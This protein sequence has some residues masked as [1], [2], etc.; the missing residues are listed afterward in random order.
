MK[1][2]IIF[3]VAALVVYC[4]TKCKNAPRNLLYTTKDHAP[5]YCKFKFQETDSTTQTI[6]LITRPITKG[7][8]EPMFMQTW[9][10]GQRKDAEK[11]VATTLQLYAKNAQKNL[12][13]VPVKIQATYAHHSFSSQYYYTYG[14]GKENYTEPLY[15]LIYPDDRNTPD[16]MNSLFVDTKLALQEYPQEIKAVITVKWTGG[17]KEVVIFLTLQEKEAGSKVRTNPFG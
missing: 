3:L 1:W 10:E 5:M 13:D 11:V 6:T 14:F 12:Y 17:E 2:F 7:T 15:S 4:F 8:D 9:F 16:R